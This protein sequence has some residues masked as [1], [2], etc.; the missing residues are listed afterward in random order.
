MVDGC[1][2][3]TAFRRVILPLLAPGLVAASIYALMTAWNEYLFAYVLLQDN[4]KYTLSVWLLDFTTQRGTDY[5]ALMAGFDPH[6]PARGDL[7][8]VRSAQ[9]CLRPDGRGG[10]GMTV[11]SI[12]MPAD[13]LTRD[14][15]TVLQPGFVGTTAP[16]WLLRL[17]GEGLGSVG[18]FARNIESPEQLAALTAQLRAVR[19]EVLV[20]ADEEGGDVTRLEARGGSSFPGNLALGAVDDLKLTRA[21]A[22]ELGRLAGRLRGQLQLGAL[23]R[24]QL[25][26]GQPGDRRTVLRRGPGAGGP[27]HRRLCRRA[28]VGR[29]GRLCQ[30]LPRARRHRDR[31]APGD[32]AD[33]RRPRDA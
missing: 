12:D 17:L 29:S 27:Q 5:G 26:P 23:G 9:G 3:M 11:I 18:L 16:E 24:R 1:S 28:P 14:A 32:A 15:L 33:R 19:P 31:L 8:P 30:A 22:A 7:L 13:V 10:E 6:R 4:D 21:V 20:A 2:Q 25:R